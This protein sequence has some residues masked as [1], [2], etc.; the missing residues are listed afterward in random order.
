MGSGSLNA[1]SVRVTERTGSPSIVTDALENVAV[2]VV[3][4]DGLNA[5]VA[6]LRECSALSAQALS[7]CRRLMSACS[8]TWEWNQMLIVIVVETIRGAKLAIFGP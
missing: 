2:E 3:Q 7:R 8:R 1:P 6:C 5:Q 4:I